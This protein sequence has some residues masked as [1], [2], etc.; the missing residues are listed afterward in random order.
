MKTIQ[1][2]LR[3]QD[4]EKIENAFFCQYP[5]ELRNLCGSEDETLGE[6]RKRI[7]VRFRAYIERLRTMKVEMKDDE[8]WVLFAYKGQDNESI[9][10]KEV[11]LLRVREL[12]ETDDLSSVQTY[13]YIFTEQKEALGFWV[14]DTKLTQDNLMDVICNF[15]HEVSFFGYEQERLKEE[16]DKLEKSMNEIDEHP[17]SLRPF[18]PEELRRELGFPEEEE[19]PE[20]Q[21]KRR[22]Y[23]AAALEYTDYCRNIEMERIKESVLTGRQGQINA[24]MDDSA[25]SCL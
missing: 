21:E 18:N 11:G 15:C 3:E 14:A 6:I 12:L 2:I 19:Y 17:E 16:A 8:N 23:Y 5:V 9:P 22:K 1:Q 10:R 4:P 24:I 25:G 13:S 7:S 20:E